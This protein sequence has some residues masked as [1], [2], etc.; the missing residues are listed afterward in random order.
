MVVVEVFLNGMSKERL[1]NIGSL[2]GGVVVLKKGKIVSQNLTS[3]TYKELLSLHGIKVYNLFLP[4]E[5][6]INMQFLAQGLNFLSGINNSCV[7]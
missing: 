2:E 3:L 5:Y 4:V 1:G 7:T 6:P